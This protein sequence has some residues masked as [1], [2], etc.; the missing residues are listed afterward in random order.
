MSHAPG[1]GGGRE[2]GNGLVTVAVSYF[3]YSKYFV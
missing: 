1:A 2:R 3:C